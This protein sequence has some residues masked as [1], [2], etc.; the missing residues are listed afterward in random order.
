MLS[1]GA[2]WSLLDLIL[3]ALFP[4]GSWIYIIYQISRKTVSGTLF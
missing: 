3:L 2:F 1:S 4:N